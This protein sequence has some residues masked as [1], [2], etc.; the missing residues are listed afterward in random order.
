MPR[1]ILELDLSSARTSEVVE[2]GQWA[3]LFRVVAHP[4]GGNVEIQFDEGEQAVPITFIG[5][6]YFNG[7]DASRRPK[8]IDRI[9]VTNT[10]ASGT[11]KLRV[12][13][14]GSDVDFQGASA[15][16][17]AEVVLANYVPLSRGTSGSMYIGDPRI[18]A[19]SNHFT[20]VVSGSG[21][22]R[23]LPCGIITGLGLVGGLRLMVPASATANDGARAYPSTGPALNVDA[24]LQP[25]GRSWGDD[26]WGM[27]IADDL[28][29]GDYVATTGS[30]LYAFFGLGWCWHTGAA[31]EES[32]CGF[33]FPIHLGPGGDY[34]PRAA[35]RESTTPYTPVANEV[36]TGV[37]WDIIH[38]YRIQWGR[39]HG[40][41][42][43]EWLID[44]VLQYSASVPLPTR[45]RGYS[46]SF[47]TPFYSIWKQDATSVDS[48]AL[49]TMIGRGATIG[50]FTP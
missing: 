5:Q 22:Y 15:D 18:S 26:S 1:K 37:R 46:F 19:A 33:R 13:D 12:S 35:L 14:D 2:L 20:G 24:I 25:H 28:A 31:L 17:S 4:G 32:F 3:D 9:R 40:V 23:V 38:R 21:T 16:E 43:L 41:P 45:F 30:L 48:L 7:C 34:A 42:F 27:F 49:H 6:R 47:Y 8:R 44:G 39:R 11:L 36:L 50:M 29:V 10:A